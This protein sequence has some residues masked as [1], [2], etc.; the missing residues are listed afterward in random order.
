M[1]VYVCQEAER[2]LWLPL[3][4]GVTSTHG[5]YTTTGQ[6]NMQNNLTL[7]TR[8]VSRITDCL[9]SNTTWRANSTVYISEGT[10]K[11][12]RVQG[13]SAVSWEAQRTCKR[14]ATIV[15]GHNIIWMLCLYSRQNKRPKVGPRRE[16][17]TLTIQFLTLLMRIE[18]FW[19]WAW[20]RI[21]TRILEF[22]SRWDKTHYDLPWARRIRLVRNEQILDTFKCF[23]YYKSIKCS[24]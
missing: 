24:L 16:Q 14:T 19:C 17:Q 23:F 15:P 3:S 18:T 8:M 1:V 6:K 13:C 12:S 21:E 5:H 7:L 9:W 11:A 22:S 10:H 4:F 20:F 2:N